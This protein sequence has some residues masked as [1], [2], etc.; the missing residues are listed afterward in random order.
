MEDLETYFRKDEEKE[1]IEG[2][3]SNTQRFM[4]IFEQIADKLIP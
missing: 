2:F 1:L 3:K 4:S